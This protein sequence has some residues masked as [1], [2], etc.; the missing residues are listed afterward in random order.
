MTHYSVKQ[1]SKLAGV[2]VRT[3]HH[4]DRIGLL[5]PAFRSEKGYRFYERKELLQL[6][7]ILFY[8]ELDFPLKEIGEIINNPD[9][10]LINALEFHKKELFLR[11]KRL[12]ELLATIEKTIIEL[13]TKNEVMKDIEIYKGFTEA[14][15]KSMKTEVAQRWGKDKLVESENRIRK[16]GEQGWEDTKNKGEEI[17]QLL[18]ELMDFAPSDPKVQKAIDVHHRFT[19]QFFD[20][21][22][23]GY[24]GL[25]KMYVEDER[26]NSHY[27]KYRPNLASFI[28]AAI[29]IY[30]DNDRKIPQSKV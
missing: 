27:E 16:M 7:Q 10:D 30:C 9:F 21:S 5:K 17:S 6:Q 14:E 25:G 26:F 8:K 28:Q 4:Y 29:N 1:L 24:R 12:S 15:M 18:A 22:L 2:S 23:E 20:V 19:N 3:L 11:S 13:K